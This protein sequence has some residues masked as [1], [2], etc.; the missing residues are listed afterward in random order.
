MSTNEGT[1][2]LKD[3][4]E[5]TKGTEG[6][7]GEKDEKK[8]KEKKPEVPDEELSAF[9]MRFR[10]ERHCQDGE[11]LTA[12]GRQGARRT[13]GGSTPTANPRM[14]ATPRR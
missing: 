10:D 9:F 14:S 8:T 6:G 12:G 2:L 3:K 1:S 4:E 5:V 7:E 13:M 11:L